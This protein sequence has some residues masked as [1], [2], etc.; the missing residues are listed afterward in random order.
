[1][2]DSPSRSERA[3]RTAASPNFGEGRFRNPVPTRGVLPGRLLD[4]IVRRLR[5]GTETE[6]RRELPVLRPTAAD[7]AT[8][9]ANGVRATWLGHSSVLL[10]IDGATLLL[11]PV[12]AERASPFG[13]AGPRRFHPP[14]M[15]LEAL[16]PLDAVLVSH[17]H[18]DH[19]D[20]AAVS[21]LAGRGVRIVTSLGVG[22]RLE[23]WGIPPERI[24]ELDWHESTTVSSLTVTAT[25]A[26][27]FSGRG[28]RDRDRSLWS[29]WVIAGPTRRA[30]FSG[31]TGFFEALGEIGAA[32]GPFDLNLI[33]IGAYSEA[34][35]D[36]HMTPEEAVRAHGLLGGSALLAIHW[37][38]FDLAFHAWNEPPERLVR[39]AGA[40]GVEVFIPRPGEVVDPALPLEPEPWWRENG[41]G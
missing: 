18:Y 31:D 39:A 41:R 13:F 2:D 23:R 26:R 30:F 35:P 32:H 16:P 20:R 15:A 1:M 10:E 27:H 34:W 14:P 33:K 12:W 37:G 9:P 40:A 25:P 22:E 19:L 21:A 5:E 17:D 3:A 28:I 38:T 8:P 4:Q 24:T 36:V 29:S 6:P 11:D 7:Y